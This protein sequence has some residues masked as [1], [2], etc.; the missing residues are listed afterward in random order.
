MTDQDWIDRI[1][2]RW[3][4]AEYLAGRLGMTA[5]QAMANMDQ[6]DIEALVLFREGNDLPAAVRN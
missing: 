5:Q 1:A 2:E 3:E 4:L 6:A